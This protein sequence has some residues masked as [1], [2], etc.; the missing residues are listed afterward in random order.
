[1]IDLIILIIFGLLAYSLAFMLVFKQPPILKP[2]YWLFK[3]VG[4]KDALSCIFCMGFWSS[5]FLSALNIFVLSNIKFTMLLTI[6]GFPETWLYKLIYIVLD[7][8]IGAGLVYLIHSFQESLEVKS[9]QVNYEYVDS[10]DIAEKIN[11]SSSKQ[12]LH[13]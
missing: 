1:M 10:S 3:F 9:E 8:F 7:G 2:L 4:L 13:D 11:L 6:N 5:A 12:I